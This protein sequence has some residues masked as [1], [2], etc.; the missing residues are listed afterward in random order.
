MDFTLDTNLTTDWGTTLTVDQWEDLG[1]DSVRAASSDELGD[2]LDGWTP[3]EKVRRNIKL[4]A[5]LD[6]IEVYESNIQELNEALANGDIG[7]DEWETRMGKNIKHLHMNAHMIGRSGNWSEL[8]REEVQALEDEVDRQLGY[9]RR[10]RNELA[11]PGRLDDVSEQKLNIRGSLY[12]ASSSASFE[13]GYQAERGLPPGVLPA[14]PGDGST[15]CLT[16]CHCRWSIRTISKER[17]DFDANWR[18]GAAEHCQTCRDRARS[19]LGLRI[20]GGELQTDVE[21][22]FYDR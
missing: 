12:G 1:I 17:G 11:Q 18:L 2:Y 22:I 3:G 21:P 16:N 14:Q 7:L 19:W 20:R 8:T 5:L 6:R 15:R 4:R 9:L 13:R 10:W